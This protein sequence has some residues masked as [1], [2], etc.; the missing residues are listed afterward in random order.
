MRRLGGGGWDRRTRQR[1]LRVVLTVLAVALGTVA[2]WLIVTS[3]SAQRTKIGAL[4]GFWA[5]LIAAYPVL[6]MRHPQAEQA[7]RAGQEVDLRP[8]GNL[9]RTEDAASRLEYERRLQQMIRHEI[10]TALGSELASLRSEVAALR[11]EILEKVGGQIR[12]ERIETTRMIGSDIEAL[13][14]EVRQLKVANHPD[15][16]GGFTVD[17]TELVQSMD[18]AVARQLAAAEAEHAER[19]R[20]LAAHVAEVEL[21]EVEL[22]EVELSPTA[23]EQPA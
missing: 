10:H 20:Q 18:D 12:L 4:A 17:A 21:A 22:A 23:S 6:G 8:A 19:L 1:V 7:G 13:Q 3:E 11:S 9:E 2:V 14:H 15:G 5:L 16:M